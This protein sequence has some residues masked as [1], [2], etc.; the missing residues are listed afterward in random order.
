MACR[1]NLAVET[2]YRLFG[3]GQEPTVGDTIR[4][5]DG[6]EEAVDPA[7]SVSHRLPEVVEAL[8]AQPLDLALREAGCERHLRQQLHGRSEPRPR[9]LDLDG[10]AI[11]AGTRRETGT[12]PLGSLHEGHGVPPHRAFRHGPCRQHGHTGLPRRLRGGTTARVPSHDDLRLQ[13]RATRARGR[14]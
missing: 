10:Q 12:Q 11:P 6:R 8:L 14:G 3:S 2:W 4:V 7:A 1:E 13:Q 5:D 9:H